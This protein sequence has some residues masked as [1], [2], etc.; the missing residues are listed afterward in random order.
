MNKKVGLLAAVAISFAMH[1]F[2]EEAV[3]NVFSSEDTRPLNDPAGWSLGAVPSSEKGAV[4]SGKGAFL[5]PEIQGFSSYSLKSGAALLVGP[6]SMLSDM[7]LEAGA[8]LRV[9]T[10][11]TYKKSGYIT[12]TENNPTSL[13]GMPVSYSL[14]RI[15]DIT[16]CIGGATW[17]AGLQG[18]P[19]SNVYRFNYREADGVQTEI[20]QFQNYIANYDGNHTKGVVV[21]IKK[22]YSGNITAYVKDGRY[23]N[24]RNGLG[25]DL[26]T[27]FS[28]GSADSD[29]GGGYGVKDIVFSVPIAESHAPVAMNEET[30]FS[31]VGEGVVEIDVAE[32][33][34]LDLSRARVSAEASIVKTGKG[35]IVI[36]PELTGEVLVESGILAVQLGVPYDMRKVT[37][38][39]DVEIMGFSEGDF[40]YVRGVPA[41]DGK[42]Q[43]LK[44]EGAFE[45]S[46]SEEIPSNGF[47]ALSV[48][49]ENTT[50][51]L[52]SSVP[53]D[54]LTEVV[55]DSGATLNILSSVDIKKLVLNGNAS[56]IVG[57]N[58]NLK[59]RSFEVTA[60]DELKASMWVMSGGNMKIF[61]D[62]VLPYIYLK[63][64]ASLELDS[65]VSMSEWDFSESMVGEGGEFEVFPRLTICKYGI[66]LV[67][68]DAKFKNINMTV[69]GA[70]EASSA[71]AIYFG[72]AKSG[73][74][75]RFGLLA[76]GASFKMA[77]GVENGKGGYYFASP[78]QGGRVKVAGAIRIKD[79][80]FNLAERI[81][82]VKK[83][84]GFCFGKNNPVDEPLLVDI[85]GTV[86]DCT[87]DSYIGGSA[88][89]SFGDGGVLRNPIND[90]QRGRAS[91]IFVV[92]KARLVFGEGSQ[93]L[94][95]ISGNWIG[96]GINFSPDVDDEYPALELKNGGAFASYVTKGNGKAR[97]DF[98]SAFFEVICGTWHGND[99]LSH[100]FWHFKAAHVSK[101]DTLTIRRAKYDIG[102]NQFDNVS[103][104]TDIVA[105][106][107][108]DGDVVVT[109]A[110]KGVGS[111]SLIVQ[112]GDNEN[113]GKISVHGENCQLWF[114]DGANWK[115]TV[116]ANGK[117]G[118]SAIHY[119]ND[120]TGIE[121][122]TPYIADG[123]VNADGAIPYPF[124]PVTVAF[125]KLDLQ[126][127][128]PVKVWKGEEGKITG[129]DTLNVGE[130]INN[131][132][133]LVPE[134]ATENGEFVLGD[135]IVVGEIG[136]SSPLPRVAKGWTASRKTIDG[137]SMLMLSKGVGFLMI[138]R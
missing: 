130:Y 28:Y 3:E 17:T 89:V 121:G 19:Y 31:A 53:V 75:S 72:Y 126:S 127:D 133:R 23:F 85:T 42:I 124:A 68:G 48:S 64:S 100:V 94:Y 33:C 70:I 8:K 35:A 96:S 74:V 108:G 55:V 38:A 13:G 103:I 80:N 120:Y 54:T 117:T 15:S 77:D 56:L 20:W 90:A 109:N 45:Y 32:K 5:V 106:I 61:G 7:T 81:G 128:F 101:G 95:P 11:V 104:V 69:K 24:N 79:S 62:G 84:Q 2:G 47:T 116:V 39:E 92:D 49:G 34:I 6:G 132:G 18:T 73:E 113:T 41:E 9:D 111:F 22:D 36:G 51:V 46:G 10:K 30:A 137:K 99:R 78:E 102:G 115:G 52:D 91:H 16:G 129:N 97:V 119:K 71:G 135:K 25:E 44:I 76:D 43:Y 98:K 136:D 66:L 65:R 1:A 58:G 59:L 87:A 57:E 29:G 123:K 93:F 37:F 67:P 107:K 138:V 114:A 105:P 21:E 112:R 82:A 40:L 110:T 88:V 63:G 86:I 83:Y 27:G 118:I 26:M 50:F 12:K 131:G 125:A 14:Q 134:M 4:I 122:E 60:Q